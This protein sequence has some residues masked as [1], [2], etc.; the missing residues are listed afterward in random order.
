[1]VAQ[2]SAEDAEGR[3]E[4]WFLLK[5]TKNQP[6]LGPLLKTTKNQACAGKRKNHQKTVKHLAVGKASRGWCWQTSGVWIPRALSGLS[7]GR[8]EGAEGRGVFVAAQ[9]PAPPRPFL[10]VKKARDVQ[11]SGAALLLNLF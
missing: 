11:R 1:M 4:G 7:A 5:T 8:P 10:R 3:V 6:P 2:P 9:N